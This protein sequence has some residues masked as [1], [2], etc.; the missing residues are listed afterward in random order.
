M[1]TMNPYLN[2]SGNTGEAFNFYRSVFGGTFS[3]LQR[4]GD[5]PH[6]SQMQEMNGKRSCILPVY[7]A[8][9]CVDGYRCD[10]VYGL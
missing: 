4:F 7:I 10:S 8:G 5:T 2:F 1:T 6:G 9:L 3:M